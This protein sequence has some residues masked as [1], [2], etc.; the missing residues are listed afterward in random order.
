VLS[1]RGLCDGSTPRPEESYRECGSLSVIKRK[2]NTLHLKC[3][4]RKGLD[5]ERKNA[6]IQSS[7]CPNQ[8]ISRE[9]FCTFLLQ[10]VKTEPCASCR[11]IR[12]ENSKNKDHN[13]D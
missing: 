9:I 13:K 12:N 10:R 3:L 11:S 8:I 6:L 1:G 7:H 4:G 2:N 5:Y